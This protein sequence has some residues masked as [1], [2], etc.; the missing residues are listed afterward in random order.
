GFSSAWLVTTYLIIAVEFAG[1]YVLPADIGFVVVAAVI[2]GAAYQWLSRRFRR[3]GISIDFAAPIVWLGPVTGLTLNQVYDHL[4][5]DTRAALQTWSSDALPDGTILVEGY[6][7]RTLNR[8]WGGYGGR[9]RVFLDNRVT[10]RPI[11]DWLKEYVYYAELSD[12]N[13][14]ALRA[15]AP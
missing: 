7:I 9:Y 11:S 14:Q 15:T 6:N 10:E 1:Y 12:E 2:I 13:L 4:Q 3:V 5:P 8:E